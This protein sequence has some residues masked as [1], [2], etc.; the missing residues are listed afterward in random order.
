LDKDGNLSRGQ[1]VYQRIRADIGMLKLTA[2]TALVEQE[3]SDRY[4][5]SRTP[6]REA[7]FRLEQDGFV[8]RQ[9]RQLYVRTFGIAE[10]EDLYHVREAL[11][12][13]AVRLCI[14]RATDDQLDEARRQIDSYEHIYRTEPHEVFVDFTNRF[15]WLIAKLSGNSALLEQLLNVS[16]KVNIITAKYMQPDA[17]TYAAVEHMSILQALYDRDVVVAEAA[18]RAHLQKVIKFYKSG[19]DESV[20]AAPFVPAAAAP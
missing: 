20:L 12:K 7:L 18:V 11:E 10:I 16:E 4:A 13:M 3:L 15:H 19:G 17:Y 2:G 5:A 14:E 1:E 9:G 6:I 8:T